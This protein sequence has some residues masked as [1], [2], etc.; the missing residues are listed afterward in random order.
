[1]ALKPTENVLLLVTRE[2]RTRTLQLR[3]ESP[4]R[5]ELPDGQVLTLLKRKGTY[6]ELE[7][8]SCANLG[9]PRIILVLPTK[10]AEKLASV[11]A[12][13]REAL[14]AQ[15]LEPNILQSLSDPPLKALHHSLRSLETRYKH[16]SEYDRGLA[17]RRFEADR[18]LFATACEAATRVSLNALTLGEIAAA[19]ATELRADAP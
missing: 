10:D 17:E 11:L 7:H 4:R 18:R 3:A 16:Q 6:F 19:V 13:H 8:D 2:W 5:L 9:W 1:M 12:Q 15:G 14:C